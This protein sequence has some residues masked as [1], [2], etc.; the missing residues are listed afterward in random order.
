M[1]GEH[2]KMVCSKLHERHSCGMSTRTWFRRL[3]DGF[4]PHLLFNITI[5]S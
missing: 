5:V 4:A 2:R 1:W 3:L